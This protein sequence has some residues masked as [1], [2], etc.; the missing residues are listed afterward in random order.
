MDGIKM[1]KY[2]INLLFLLTLGFNSIYSMQD[3][4]A[5]QF[6]RLIGAIKTY[7]TA[8]ILKFERR[9]FHMTTD[10]LKQT[11]L[12]I[13][14]KSDDTDYPLVNALIE[15]YR[16][17]VNSRDRFGK[18]PLHLVSFNTSD[19]GAAFKKSQTT[20]S[21]PPFLKSVEKARSLIKHGADI[22][23]IDNFGHTP[24]EYAALRG[25]KELVQLLIDADA[26]ITPDAIEMA[27]RRENFELAVFLA[28]TIYKAD[29][30]VPNLRLTL[31]HYASL[32]GW[33]FFC[34]Y[35][36]DEQHNY[37]NQKDAADRTPLI[38]A[39]QQHDFVTAQMIL[40]YTDDVNQ[41]DSELN[42][43]LHYAV[44]AGNEELV[45]ILL[46]KRANPNLADGKARKTALFYA[47]E[48][49]QDSEQ[50]KE[51]AQELF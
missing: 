3:N 38:C 24:L 5:E 34:Q 19:S 27:T 21:Q 44:K 48:L 10:N 33:T 15:E 28:T 46:S 4:D 6:K 37:P 25:Q 36:L 45:R 8:A 2:G 20:H 11:P 40:R 7:N 51:A 32:H 1:F 9:F 49:P 41:P 47:F 43:P 14:V 13:A 16:I 26:R 17:D 23:A 30:D 18:T 42:T 22:N 12:H 31:L 29:P 35:L 50:Q 39:L